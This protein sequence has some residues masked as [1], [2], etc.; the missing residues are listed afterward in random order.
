MT[1]HENGNRGEWSLVH[2]EPKFTGSVEVEVIDAVTLPAAD[3]IK[4]DTEGA[5]TNIVKRLHDTGKLAAVNAL[6]LEY[7]SASHVAPLIWYAQE[8]GLKL[9]SVA[10]HLEHR[11]ILKFLR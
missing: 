10:P 1:L 5:E 9:H 11:G 8:S 2:F 4:I 7:H 6:V 3:F